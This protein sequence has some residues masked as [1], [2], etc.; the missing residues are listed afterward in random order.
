[1]QKTITFFFLL[2][3]PNLAN[4]SETLIEYYVEGSLSN[5][6]IKDATI[7]IST[8]NGWVNVTEVYLHAAGVNSLDCCPEIWD[9]IEAHVSTMTEPVPFSN[10]SN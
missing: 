9:A 8:K 10:F 4:P 6:E 7:A 2:P 1:M 5:G 3:F